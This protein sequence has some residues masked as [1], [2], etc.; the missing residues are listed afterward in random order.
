MTFT[1]NAELGRVDI[2]VN[3]AAISEKILSAVRDFYTSDDP[4]TPGNLIFGQIG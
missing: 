3:N 4:A 1:L 2:L